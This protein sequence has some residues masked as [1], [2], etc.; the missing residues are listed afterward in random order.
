MSQ[1]YTLTAQPRITSQRQMDSLIIH[2]K[3]TAFISSCESHTSVICEDQRAH[4]RESR[5][6]RQ[7]KTS[8]WAVFFLYLERINNMYIFAEELSSHFLNLKI[9]QTEVYHLSAG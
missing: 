4:Q 9:R 7:K 6:W 5:R 3:D 1:G 2:L 8:L